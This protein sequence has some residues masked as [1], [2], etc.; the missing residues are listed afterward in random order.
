MD[1]D[2][3]L[4]CKVLL[5]TSWL[6]ILPAHLF[7]TQTLPQPITTLFWPCMPKQSV[8]SLMCVIQADL[9]HGV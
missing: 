4:S 1:M 8:H 2:R 3:E 9:H 7:S 5:R 6:S